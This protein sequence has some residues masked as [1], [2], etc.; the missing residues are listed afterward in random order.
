MSGMLLA[1]P[2]QLDGKPVT[3]VENMCATGAEALR[4]AAYAVASGAYDL[5]MAVGVEKVKDSG[6]QGLNAFPVPNDG[7]ARNL[8]AAAMFSMVG[9]AYADRYGVS[10]EEMR[11][12]L[13][14][15]AWKNH[16]NGAR[17]PRAQLRHEVSVEQILAMSAVAGDL[18]V[19]H[20]AGVA[21]GDAAAI[22]FRAADPKQSDGRRIGQER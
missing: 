6:Y 14:R 3:R 8:T 21:A 1:K 12:V 17:N 15:I 7:T 10:P 18:S 16:A 2:L 9:P 13:A 4:Q 20:C 5:A 11:A 19:Y 22:L